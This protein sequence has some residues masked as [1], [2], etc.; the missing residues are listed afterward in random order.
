MRG[1]AVKKIGKYEIRG[2]LGKGGMAR[3]YKVRLPEIGKVVALKL[4]APHPHLVDLLGMAEINRRFRSEA[5]TLAGLR[6][7]HIVGIWDFD[8][9]DGR[10]FFTMEY[11][12]NNLGLVLGETYRLEDPARPLSLDKAIPYALQLLNGLSRMHQAGI[13][14]RDIKPYNILLTDED[15]VKISDFGLS[16]LRGEAF[17]RPPHLMVGSPYYAAP[18]QEE[19]PDGVDARADI[20]SVG[21]VLHRMLTGNLAVGTGEQPS[22]CR[23]DLDSAWD[24]FLGKATA[25]HPEDRYATAAEMLETLERLT[26]AWNAKKAQVC[27]AVEALYPQRRTA[28]PARCSMRNRSITV[29]PDQ[30]RT[31]FGLDEL[32]RPISYLRNDFRQTGDGTIQDRATGLIWQQAG[33]DFPLSW[34]EAHEYVQQLNVQHVARR[35]TWRLPTIAELLSLLTPKPHTRDLCIEPVFCEDKKCLWSA[36]RRSALA[37][38][39]VSIDV[40]FVAWQDRTCYFFVRAVCGENDSSGGM[41]RTEP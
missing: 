14:H 13:V 36:D 19:D 1:G 15:T 29:R 41:G 28:A 26:R 20:Y 3:V 32:W 18:E 30:A 12:C 39:Y 31:V 24:G 9:C 11:Y 33:S 4:L 10:P 35:R 7:P 40:G 5:V 27:P 6:H 23:P 17:P 21:V 25:S 16:K 8:E 37:A 22:A 38:W 2:L 34:D